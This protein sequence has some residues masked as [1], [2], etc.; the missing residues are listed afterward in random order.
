MIASFI[1]YKKRALFIVV[2]CVC[3]CGCN[4]Q[5]SFTEMDQ[6]FVNPQSSNITDEIISAVDDSVKEEITLIPEEPATGISGGKGEFNTTRDDEVPDTG[7]WSSLPSP[8]PDNQGVKVEFKDEKKKIYEELKVQHIKITEKE[9][10]KLEKTSLPKIKSE[11]SKS[12]ETTLE[13]SME[14]VSPEPD[15]TSKDSNDQKATTNLETER[16]KKS[17]KP[18]KDQAKIKPNPPENKRILTAKL[19]DK[20]LQEKKIRKS[21]VLPDKKKELPPPPVFGSLAGKVTI[22]SKGKV[23]SP[24][25]VIIVL[26]PTDPGL[27]IER[28]TKT[29]LVEMKG[30]KYQ[31]RYLHIRVNDAVIF[32]NA[33]PFMH[34]VFSLEGLNKFDLGTYGRDSEPRHT[35][36]HPGLVKV[37]CNIHPAMAC[38]IM[39]SNGD[40]GYITDSKGLFR[41]EGLPV[42]DY[43]LKAWNIRGDF[44]SAVEINPNQIA[45][46]DIQI[47]GSSFKE[48]PHLNKF[49]KKYPKISG[50]EFY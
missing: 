10:T 13:A 19:S 18:F 3:I 48:R 5:V 33:D 24:T 17:E 7:G 34:N 47:D 50:D 6:S 36:K 29:H 49:G 22:K 25:N 12:K 15:I 11:K 38:F 31:P 1:P 9:E 41:I 46:V 45:N 37:Y 23:L 44:K 2:I 8:L 26:E 39:V 20:V 32:R 28:P 35:F 40:W 4:T 30:K 42:G 43:Q 16:K 27:L 21:P 14:S